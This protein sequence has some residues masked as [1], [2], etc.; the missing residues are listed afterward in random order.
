MEDGRNRGEG[1]KGVGVVEEI[2]E[3]GKLNNYKTT[4]H[5]L[6]NYLELVQLPIRIFIRIIP[7]VSLYIRLY[8]CCLLYGIIENC[9]KQRRCVRVHVHIYLNCVVQ[10]VHVAKHK[11]F[12]FHVGA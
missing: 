3:G 2:E 7:R 4:S 10:T 12:S 9:Q 8:L 5:I 1:C 6:T 11:L